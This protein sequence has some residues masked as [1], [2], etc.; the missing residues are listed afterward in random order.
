M[1]DEERVACF[2]AN[3]KFIDRM[4][5]AIREGTERPPMVG[6]DKRPCT[7]NPRFVPHK[8]LTDNLGTRSVAGSVVDKTL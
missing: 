3:A 4:V 8:P 5:Q 6:M 1:T 2:Y 7:R